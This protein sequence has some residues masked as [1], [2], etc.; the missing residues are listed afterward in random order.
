M[1]YF[2]LVNPIYQLKYVGGL[3]EQICEANPQI[4]DQ[5]APMELTQQSVLKAVVKYNLRVFK[6]IMVLRGWQ[7][8]LESTKLDVAFEKLQDG[9]DSDIT[10]GIKMV[11]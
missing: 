10:D 2:D 5:I 4:A 11:K 7:E 9:N 1:E 3:Y 8:N 6:N